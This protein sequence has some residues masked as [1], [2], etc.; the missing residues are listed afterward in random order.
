[1]SAKIGGG[2]GDDGFPALLK[3]DIFA[4]QYF[5][6]ECT[7]LVC[8]YASSGQRYYVHLSC[9]A[10][11]YIH[12]P[13]FGPHHS[14]FSNEPA[15]FGHPAN[16]QTNSV[17]SLNWQQFFIR[18]SH[19]VGTDFCRPSSFLSPLSVFCEKLGDEAVYELRRDSRLYIGNVVHYLPQ[20][21]WTNEKN[22]NIT[23]AF[24]SH[25]PP[26]FPEKKYI[27]C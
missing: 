2:D 7:P 26:S 14:P 8:M 5:T 22:S 16:Q 15:P 27:Y 9:S 11:A 4:C 24:Q 1:M 3:S 17:E 10:A 19:I 21:Q 6:V 23:S 13:F 25:L 18:T 20:Y 12:I